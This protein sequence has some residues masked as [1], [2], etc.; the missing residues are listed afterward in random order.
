[1]N[2]LSPVTLRAW[3]VGVYAREGRGLRAPPLLDGFAAELPAGPTPGGWNAGYAH[4]PTHVWWGA[5]RG[6]TCAGADGRP[7]AW[8]AEDGVHTAQG[9]IADPLL[10]VLE[11]ATGWATRRLWVLGAAG[12]G[13]ILA[14]DDLTPLVD[15][16]YDRD[17]LT[18]DLAWLEQLGQGLAD[19]LAVGFEVRVGRR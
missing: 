2:L 16:S 19:A 10:V 9:G 12:A 1:M 17:L 18:A 6:W 5:G 4:G 14:V 3:R 13:E 11:V 15:P 7:V 8:T